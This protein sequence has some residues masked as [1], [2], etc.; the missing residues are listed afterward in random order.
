MRI[1][2]GVFEY[3]LGHATRSSLLISELIKQGHSVDIISTG[4][5][6]NFLKTK[7]KNKCKFFDVLSV[8]MPATKTR[9]FRIFFFIHSL[10]MYLNLKRARKITKEIIKKE[11]YDK[12]ISDCRYDVYDN[13]ESSYLI[14]HQLRFKSPI[15]FQDILELW[16]NKNMSRYKYVLVPDFPGE[17]NLSGDLSRN[18]KYFKKSKI[19]YIGILSQLKKTKAKK[20][21]DIFFSVTGVEPQKSIFE[22]KVLNQLK[23]TKAKIIVANGNPK[24][25]FK[26]KN[27][28]YV[29]LKNTKNQEKYT[30]RSKFIITRPGY[31]SI[32][33]FAELNIKKAL[34]IPIP[35]HTE[36]EHLAKRFEKNNFFPYIKQNKINTLNQINPS[37]KYKGFKPPWKTKE[38]IKKFLKIIGLS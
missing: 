31:T 4:D 34:L 20:D 16:L 11:N 21:I 19:K 12:I 24:L 7:F 27:I 32:M 8:S 36:Q 25:Q 23:K 15:I 22:K 13:P 14:N 35:G 10:K 29:G 1:L 17:Y 30:N 2:F 5:A 28:K 3:G 38:S 37:K 18:L 26:S 9:F 33:E 6:L